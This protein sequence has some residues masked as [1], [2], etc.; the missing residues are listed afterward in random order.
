METG[1]T[2]ISQDLGASLTYGI[3]REVSTSSNSLIS[4]RV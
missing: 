2:G 3:Q 1:P 4:G